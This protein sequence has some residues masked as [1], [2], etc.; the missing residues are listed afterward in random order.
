MQWFF[1]LKLGLAQTRLN[2]GVEKVHTAI[3]CIQTDST[4]LIYLRLHLKILS[5][6]GIKP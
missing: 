4:I 5:E 1:L 6:T 2:I 3:E